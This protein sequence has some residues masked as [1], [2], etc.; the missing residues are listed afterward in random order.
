VSSKGIL[1]GIRQG[2]HP[3]DF[4]YLSIVWIPAHLS[5]SKVFFL[6]LDQTLPGMLPDPLLLGS[7]LDLVGFV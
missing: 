6:Y 5:C 3:P 2:E 4:I 7:I 1:Q